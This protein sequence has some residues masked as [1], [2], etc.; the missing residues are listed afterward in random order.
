MAH[1]KAWEDEH[2]PIPPGM[3]VCHHCDNPPCINPDHLFLGTQKDN[4]V[5]M[6]RKG[7]HGQ[8]VMTERELELALFL[9]ECEVATQ[10]QMADRLGVAQSTLSRARR[11]LTWSW[12]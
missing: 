9:I 6:S 10:A 2:G 11:R 8:A 12:R 5:D 7:R 1:R 4:A 3:N